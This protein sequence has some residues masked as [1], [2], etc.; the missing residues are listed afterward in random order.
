MYPMFECN[1]DEETIGKKLT[2]AREGTS[3][4]SPKG[5]LK[6]DMSEQ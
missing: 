4:P 3:A 5:S 6:G 1:T 2:P